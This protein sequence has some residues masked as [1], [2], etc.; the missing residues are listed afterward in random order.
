MK[1]AALNNTRLVVALLAA[2]AIGGAGVG[3]FNAVHSP[4]L[5]ALPPAITSSTGASTPMALPD[6]SQITARW[7]KTMAAMARPATRCL[8]FSATF[9][10]ARAKVRALAVSRK[11]RRAAKA[12]ALS[13]AQTASS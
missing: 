7:H 9:S 13:S 8:N 11:C 4:A 6:F 5:A 2:G 10:K 1:F 12:R 3:A